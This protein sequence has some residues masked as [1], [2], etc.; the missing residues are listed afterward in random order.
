MSNHDLK[1]AKEMFGDMGYLS[2]TDTL[3]Y[4]RGYIDREL[5]NDLKK[6][7]ISVIIP[8]KKNMNIFKEALGRAKEEN[9]WIKH[10]NVRRK[11]Q[12]IQFVEKLGEYYVSEK[13][14]HKKIGNEDGADVELNACVIKIKKD[15][16]EYTEAEITHI[17]GK[18]K[19]IVL[20]TSDLNI[21][22]EDIVREYETRAEIEEDFRQL[23]DVWGLCDFKSTKYINIIYH[24]IMTL[25]AYNM[26]ILYKN[27]EEGSQYENKNIETSTETYEENQSDNQRQIAGF[28]IT[29]DEHFGVFSFKEFLEIFHNTTEEVAKA[30]IEVIKGPI[31]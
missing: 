6:K 2:N 10:P 4:D 22:G 21:R 9:N 15:N 5:I 28:I 26:F 1:E 27:T 3:V 7:N 31:L 25:F 16:N 14:I 24:I 18:Y 8:V 12:E 19:Y 30:I 17:E 13:N 29:K 20:I 23:K 11:K